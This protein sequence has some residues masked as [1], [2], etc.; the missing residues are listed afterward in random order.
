MAA[1]KRMYG[2]RW[3]KA[4]DGFLAHH[5]LCMECNKFGRVTAA[6]VVDH[7]VPHRGDWSIFWDKDNWQSLCKHCHD[8][9]KQR[10]EKSGTVVG[11]SET[12]MPI[13]PNHHWNR[14]G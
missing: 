13:D 7:I 9:H 5:P 3:Q 10:L 6:V 11:C 14:K 8:S 2:S 1:K 4:R 12:G